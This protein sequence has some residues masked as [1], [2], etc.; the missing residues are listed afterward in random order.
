MAD[1]SY[2]I[3]A[4]EIGLLIISTAYHYLELLCIILVQKRWHM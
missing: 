2:G 1:E 3:E 4:P